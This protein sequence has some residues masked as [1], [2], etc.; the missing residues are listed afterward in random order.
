[1]PDLDLAPPAGKATKIAA[2]SE[3]DIVTTFYVPEASRGVRTVG[4]PSP[5]PRADRGAAA[6][7]S[8]VH[9]AQRH[10][11]Y[12][13]T[14]PRLTVRKLRLQLARLPPIW[15]FRLLLGAAAV[16]FLLLVGGLLLLLG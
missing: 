4:A 1:L 15:R 7:I 10:P 9:E 11:T 8:S 3:F 5:P 13:P 14:I 12:V 6:P 16:S 2:T